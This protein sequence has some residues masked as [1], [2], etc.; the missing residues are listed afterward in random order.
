[1]PS[2][3]E[4]E[5]WP[6]RL[7][8]QFL[9]PSFAKFLVVGVVNAFN[10]VLFAYL[11]SLIWNANVAFVAGYAV[12]LTISYLL[13]SRFVFPT[14][15]SPSRYWRFV[16]SYV[17]NFLIQNLCVLVFYNWLGWHKLVAFTLA[18]IIGVPVT[19]LLLKFFAFGR[20]STRG[21]VASD[22]QAED[23]WPES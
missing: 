20:A 4:P 19:F 15:L 23:V 7:V 13:N 5:I 6:A 1:M 16:V 11:F 9:T 22:V 18:A 21:D 10:G 17:P 14:R 3:P 12:A 8:R 2:A